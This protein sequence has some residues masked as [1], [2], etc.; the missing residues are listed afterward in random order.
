MSCAASRWRGER[1]EKSKEQ[2]ALVAHLES[3][4]A[5]ARMSA[6]I[7]RPATSALIDLVCIPFRAAA[8]S[9]A[10]MT[11]CEPCDCENRRIS[12]RS[13]AAREPRSGSTVASSS[14]L[15]RSRRTESLFQPSDSKMVGL[16]WPP[17]RTREAWRR[18]DSA[19]NS[20]GSARGRY[21]RWAHLRGVWEFLANV[22]V[23]ALQLGV[24]RGGRPTLGLVRGRREDVLAHAPSSRVARQ[25]RDTPPRRIRADSAARLAH[26]GE[27]ATRGNDETTTSTSTR[28]TS[29]KL[30]VDDLHTR[31]A[32]AGDAGNSLPWRASSACSCSQ[33]LPPAPPWRVS[34]TIPAARRPRTA[35]SPRARPAADRPSARA[36]ACSWPSS[37]IDLR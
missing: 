18:Q 9:R 23:H 35:L 17:N 26:H 6:S 31:N 22:Q 32:R 21:Q 25:D 8:R 5:I 36:S 12:N 15:I 33:R 37:A 28:T 16:G 30:S 13:R 11:P 14:E 24:H 34:A 7:G 27:R 19:A 2:G 10:V 4:P 1:R 3:K 29:T 20:R